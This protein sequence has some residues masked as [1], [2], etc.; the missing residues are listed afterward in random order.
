MDTLFPQRQP[1]RKHEKYEQLLEM[2]RKVPPLTAAIAHPCDE[3]SLAGAVDAARLGL[4]V[5]LLVGPAARIGAAAQ[6]ARLD[7]SRYEI[8]DVPHSYAAAQR[9]VQTYSIT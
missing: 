9:A 4:L 6:K 2:A 1:V 7:I 8:V 3:S 5:P